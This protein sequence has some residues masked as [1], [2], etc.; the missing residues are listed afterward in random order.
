MPGQ[1]SAGP[2]EDTVQKVDDN[3]R[4]NL[5]ALIRQWGTAVQLA[6]ALGLNGSSYIGHLLSQRKP[7]T[8][9]T[10]RA[11]EK[12]LAL[13]EMWFDK[14]HSGAHQVVEFNAE[15]LEKVIRSVSEASKLNPVPSSKLGTIVVEAYTRAAQDGQVDVDQLRR[16][17]E[18]AK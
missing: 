1:L 17:L 11:F 5:E 14:S 7:F 12:K 8:E 2:R 15:L 16:L 9:R 3:R 13:P 6:A 10:A 18:L 4:E